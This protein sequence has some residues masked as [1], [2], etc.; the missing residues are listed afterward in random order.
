MDLRRFVRFV[1]PV[2][3]VL[4]AAVMPISTT[5]RSAEHRRAFDVKVE[6]SGPPV[7]LIPGLATTGA[8]WDS[9]V[10]RLKDRYEV[11]TLTLAGFGGPAA[12]GE[13]FLPRVAAAISAYVAERRLTRPVLVGHSLGAFVAFMAAG[14]SPGLFGGVVAVDGVPYLPAL[15]NP[16]A[17]PAPQAPQAEQVKTLYRT[18]TREQYLAQSGL[19]LSSMITAPADQERA[20]AWAASADPAA[21]GIAVAEMMTT[22]LREAAARITAPV[23]LIGALGAA[24]EP[25]RDT[26][27]AAYRSQVAAVPRASV[28]FAERAR[29]FIMLDDPAFF[30]ST[31]ESFLAGLASHSGSPAPASR[32]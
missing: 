27:R 32:G 31:L 30:F 16:A 19:A 24:P 8:V 28:V 6:G 23:L 15:A 18:M 9:T 13:P 26:F 10:A 7:L 14:E 1:L 25:M 21:A 4:T 22:D 20:R 3:A 11:H 5:A 12:L 2:A 17:T 29:H